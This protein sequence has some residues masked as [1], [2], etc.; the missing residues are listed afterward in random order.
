MNEK[1]IYNIW[2]C[3][4]GRCHNEN[5]N[6]YFTRVYY[7]EKGIKVCDDWRYSFENFK[8]WALQNGYEDNL[9]IDRIDSDGN[10]EPSNCRW[11][12]L[13]ENRKLGLAN[14]GRKNSK[15]KSKPRCKKN[16]IGKWEIRSWTPNYEIVIENN[17]S[18]QEAEEHMKK[19]PKQTYVGCVNVRFVY[20]IRRMKVDSKVGKLYS[21]AN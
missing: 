5:W 10:Y 6:N 17:L 7:R 14:G 18:K 4:V 8:M 15:Q 19:L 16:H 9:S 1:R 20:V 21:K 11:I 2:R 12:P 13:D 3:M